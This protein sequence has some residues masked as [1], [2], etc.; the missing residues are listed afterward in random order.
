MIKTKCIICGKARYFPCKA[1]EKRRNKAK[2]CRS[3]YLKNVPKRDKSSN[4]KG[5]RAIHNGYIIIRKPDH[6]FCKGNG[7]VFEHRLVMEKHIGRYLKQGEQIHHINGDKQ[8]NRIKNLILT[9][10]GEHCHKYHK[11]N[12]KCSLCNQKHIARGFC[13][14]HYWINFLKQHRSKS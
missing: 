6:P 8:D 7:Y 1:E 5:G 9:K 11:K 12:R 4:W 13:K 3:C 10:N 14:K 2:M